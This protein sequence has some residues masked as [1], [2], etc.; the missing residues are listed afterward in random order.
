LIA[1]LA[2]VGIKV[3]ANLR[4]VSTLRLSMFSRNHYVIFTERDTRHREIVILRD[5]I[6]QGGGHVERIEGKTMYALM[7]PQLAQYMVDHPNILEIRTS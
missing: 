1:R 5:L 3:Q 7:D 4:T 2:G 6:H